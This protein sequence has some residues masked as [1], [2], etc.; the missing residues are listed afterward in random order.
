MQRVRKAREAL[1]AR[2]RNDPAVRMIDI[3]RTGDE[4]ALR[5]HVDPRASPAM[6]AAFPS[7]MLGIPVIV[8]AADYRPE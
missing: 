5:I 6:R 8:I 4:L 7:R 1:A 3:G 2:L